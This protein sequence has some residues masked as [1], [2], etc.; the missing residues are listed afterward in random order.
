MKVFFVRHG[1][2]EANLHKRFAGQSDAKLTDLGRAQ[3]EAIRPILADIPFDKVYSSDL[4]RAYDT[5]TLALPGYE[6]EKLPQLR[7]I[8][9]GN[10]AGQSIT[11][12]AAANGGMSPTA[13]TGDYTPYGGENWQM[14]DARIAGFLKDLEEKPYE[15]VAVFAHR[16]VLMSV[17]RNILAVDKF[18][19][20]AIFCDNCAVNVLEYDGNKWSVLALN[21]G[22]K[23]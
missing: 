12:V 15:T 18:P 22:R 9:V 7:E 14:L 8:S 13:I 23:I 17:L 2:S 21:Y 16:G 11:A 19:P 5:Q 4:S 1:Q 20:G 6:A 10:L 3:A